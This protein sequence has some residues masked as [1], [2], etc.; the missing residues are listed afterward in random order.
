MFRGR[1]WLVALLLTIAVFIVLYGLTRRGNT[2]L[3]SAPPSAAE[4]LLVSL[5]ADKCV[6]CHHRQ[7]P[8]IVEE[9]ARS[10]HAVRGTLCSNCH[11][12][13]KAHPTA[14]EHYGTYI[15]RVV[16]PGK[17]NECHPNE[18]RQFAASRHSIP[19]W[20]A[21]VGYKAL[22]PH[23]QEMLDRIPEIRHAPGGGELPVGFVGAT[24][25]ALY[26][27]E[28]KVV[29]DEP[30]RPGAEPHDGRMLMGLACEACHQVG[31]PNADGTAGNCNTCHLRHR[32]SLEQV[33]RPETCNRCHIGPDHPQW[34]IYQESP[35][36]ILYAT[37]GDHW[38]WNQVPGRLT[39]A[40]FPAPTCQICHMS[41]FGPQPTTHDVG[42]R[43][44]WFLFP[45]TSNPRPGGDENRAR[46]QSICLQCH[47]QPFVD[48]LYAKADVATRGVNRETSKAGQMLAGLVKDGLL[49]AD[50]FDHPIKFTAFDL[51]HY[52]GRTAKFGAWMQGPDYTQWHGLYPMLNEMSRLR[53]ESAAL[54]AGGPHVLPGVPDPQAPGSSSVS[55][56]QPSP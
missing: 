47:G 50:P 43:L 3:V 11:E 37:Q 34:E 51:W 2:A 12:V 21:M 17:C 20:A 48:D 33:R 53:A 52:Y 32:F 25:N 4:G 49:T 40:D 31:R 23:F 18:V 36:G 27:L 28:Q 56:T 22:S 15:S 44:S 10:V 5:P 38:N 7:T 29:T 39:V 54:R 14:K 46:M 8:T 9:W 55:A 45:E 16:T 26:D 42:D 24:R 30:I 35:H 19:A 41:G 13:D 1:I 6:T